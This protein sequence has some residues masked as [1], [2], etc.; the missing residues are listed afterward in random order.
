MYARPSIVV[1]A[2]VF[3][4]SKILLLRR[5][6]PPY[7]GRWA[8]PGGFV[9]AG[10][11]VET[12]A[13]REVREEVGLELTRRDLIPQAMLSLPNLNQVCLC[14]I[15]M[16]D[17]PVPLFPAAPEVLEAAWFS[18]EEFPEAELWEP[19]GAMD[20]DRLFDQVSTRRFDFYQLTDDAFRV[21]SDGIAV[22]YIWRRD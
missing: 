22:D 6:S 17:T 13:L 15:V 14:F 20:I 5:G 10:E 16:L 8:P 7:V 21:I 3:A 4:R 12:A 18:R 2:I 19:A 1:L 9:E 11:S